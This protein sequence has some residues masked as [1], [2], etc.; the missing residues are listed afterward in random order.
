MN[1]KNKFRKLLLAQKKR[2]AIQTALVEAHCAHNTAI[3]DIVTKYASHASV[4]TKDNYEAT[5]RWIHERPQQFI[6]AACGWFWCNVAGEY[7]GM[8]IAAIF[9]RRHEITAHYS[10]HLFN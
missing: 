10:K 6:D 9:D 1:N 8:T 7:Q 5:M 2:V 4:I 3:R